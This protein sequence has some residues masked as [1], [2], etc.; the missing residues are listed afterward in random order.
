[1]PDPRPL[2]HV[3]HA[4]PDLD[5]AA[6]SYSGIGFTVTPRADHPFGTSNRLIVLENGYIEIVAVTSR[7]R[8]PATGFGAQVAQ[9]LESGGGGITHFVFGSTDPPSE[10]TELG[11]DATGEI[12]TFSRPAPQIDGGIVT[13]RFECV[14]T[15]GADD[16]GAF[17]CRHLA[18]EAVWNDHNVRHANSVRRLRRATRPMSVE[19]SEALSRIC[20]SPVDNGL[21][22]AGT[23]IIGRGP[24]AI[25]FDL[26][27]SPVDIGGVTVGG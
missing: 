9:A 26:E 7:E 17:L 25:T 1:V 10:M 2:D 21:I 24:M 22:Q 14:L 23:V 13:A 12:F 4:V 15:H 6:D 8:L 19:A 3:V 5:A 11:T 18:P 20:N 27:T 16:V